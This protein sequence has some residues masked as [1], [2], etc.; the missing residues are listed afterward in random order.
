MAPDGGAGQGTCPS[1][2][3]HAAFRI[4]STRWRPR[5]RPAERVLGRARQAALRGRA[6]PGSASAGA[7]STRTTATRDRGPALPRR[8]RTGV[9]APTSASGSA[10]RGSASCG[11]R[12]RR[13]GRPAADRRTADDGRELLDLAGRRRCRT[14]T[15]TRRRASCRAG[16]ASSS[17]TTS[18]T[19]SCRPAHR[20]AV[21]KKN[22]DFLPTFLVDGFVAGLWSVET[23]KGAGDAAAGAVRRGRRGPID[24]RWRPRARPAACGSSSPRP[25]DHDAGLGLTAGSRDGLAGLGVP[26]LDRAGEA[27]VELLARAVGQ[28]EDPAAH[29]RPTVDDGHVSGRALVA[30]GDLRAARQAAMGDADEASGSGSGHRPCRCR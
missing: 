21:V 2:V 25:G 19:G 4:A 14:G 27:V 26:P 17:R 20:A 3:R 11:R 23:T 22:G 13:L 7:R 5:P 6:R 9:A 30:E 29:V 18:A 24:G 12:S 16:T 15:A 8:V 10:S 1:G 28:V